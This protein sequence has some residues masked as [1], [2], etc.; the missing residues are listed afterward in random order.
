LARRAAFTLIELSITVF[1]IALMVAKRGGEFIR[2]PLPVGARSG[3]FTAEP[4][5]VTP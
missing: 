2:H 4:G 3:G 1:I 5:N